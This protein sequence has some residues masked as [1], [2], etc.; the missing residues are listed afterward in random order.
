MATGITTALLQINPFGPGGSPQVYD[1]G[2][3]GTPTDHTFTVTN[4]GAQAATALVDAG[5]LGGDFGYKGGTYPGTGGTC[6]TA[7]AAGAQC[8]VVVTFAPT[9][10]GPKG[11]TLTLGYNDGAT[12]AAQAAQGLTGTAQSGP[13]LRIND[14]TGN[15]GGGGGSNNNPPPFDYGTWGTHVYHTFTV[16]NDGNAL[17][18]N[19]IDGGTLGG[20]FSYEAGPYPGVGGTCGASLAAGAQCTINVRFSPAGSGPRSSK[21]TLNYTNAA[22]VAQPAAFRDVMGTATLAA[23]VS[24]SDG[25]G[26]GCGESCGPYTFGSIPVGTTAEQTFFLDNNGAVAATALSD[27]GTLALPFKFKGG[28]Y[29]GTGGTCGATLASGGNCS[30][31]VV[32][33]PTSVTTSAGKLGINYDDGQGATRALSRSLSG[34]ATP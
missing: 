29:P 20:D 1:Y 26:G 7:L 27:A 33:A 18:A 15:G 11:S 17:A 34:T 32:Y 13:L 3:F 14:W 8:N 22:S 9:G 28:T 23:L 19:I 5:T 12:A 25:N 21:I 2:T 10:S 24:I 30:L 6:S 16:S 4:T 31:V